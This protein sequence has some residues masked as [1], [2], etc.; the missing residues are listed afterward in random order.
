MSPASQSANP[1]SRTAFFSFSSGIV[2]VLATLVAVALL[3]LPRTAVADTEACPMA[4]VSLDQGYGLSR[5]AF[6]PV[7]RG[8][9]SQPTSGN[10]A[11]R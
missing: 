6:Q 10:T 2:L 7:C 11:A 3:N 8:A 5:T 1:M 9:E 4:E